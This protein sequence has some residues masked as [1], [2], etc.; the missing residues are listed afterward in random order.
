MKTLLAATAVIGILVA[1]GSVAYYYL[2]LLPQQAKD[3]SAIRS[4]VAP[5]REEVQVQIQ[6]M[7]SA[8]ECYTRQADYVSKQCPFNPMK[9]DYF[10]WEKCAAKARP[11]Y[12]CP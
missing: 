2:V 1:S 3:I 10:A 12:P 4:A 9:G 8:M 11:G 5:T 7:N 6:A